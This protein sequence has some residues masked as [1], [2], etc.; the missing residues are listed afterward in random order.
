MPSQPPPANGP[1]STPLLAPGGRWTRGTKAAVGVD[2][3]RCSILSMSQKPCRGLR[4]SPTIPKATSW[5]PAATGSPATRPYGPVAWHLASEPTRV[6][7]GGRRGRESRPALAGHRLRRHGISTA[8]GRAKPRCRQ[9]PSGG[10]E[11]ILS[12]ASGSSACDGSHCE[13]WEPLAFVKQ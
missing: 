9:T 8:V 2:I 7:A 5:C 13:G 1:L 3:G 11:V 10:S 4:S 6:Q 12:W